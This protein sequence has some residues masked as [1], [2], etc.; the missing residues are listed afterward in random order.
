MPYDEAQ[1]GLRLQGVAARRGDAAEA[2]SPA[3]APCRSVRVT[4]AST[5][6]TKPART[7]VA[8]I[9]GRVAPTERI[10]IAAHVQEPGAN[11]NASGVATLAEAGAR[12]GARRFAAGRIPP[13]ER[14][15]TF[16]WLNEISG[17]RQWLQDHP[18]DA[19]NVRY[20]FSMDMTGEDV[21]KT[22]GSFLIERW[23]DPGAVWE[24]PWDPHSEWGRG[25]VRAESLKGD[26]INDAA[27]RRLRSA[28][29]ARP[30]GS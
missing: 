2:R 21:K 9:P 8:E 14:T 22:G 6:S 26:L 3:P 28:W 4:I 12:A 18:D 20:M 19:K 5:F 23:P 29:R 1:Q 16:L 24:R 25:N 15:L 13:P 10:V 7:L 11:D 30:A 17:S 27:P